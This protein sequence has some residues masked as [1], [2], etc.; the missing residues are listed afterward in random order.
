MEELEKKIEKIEKNN[1]SEIDKKINETKN[2]L[3]IL[4][5]N[6]D[7]VIFCRLKKE[8]KKNEE[9]FLK[10]DINNSNEIAMMRTLTELNIIPVSSLKNNNDINI[11]TPKSQY[12]YFL[13]SKTKS[14]NI[15]P[16]LNPFDFWNMLL[17]FKGL[18]Q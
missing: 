13:L 5:I 12:L 1:N 16:D 4:K 18:K 6:I 2:E 17:K 9:I 8:L 3:Q 14:K 10:L 15:S 7:N 11:N